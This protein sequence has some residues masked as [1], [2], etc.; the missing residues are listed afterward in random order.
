MLVIFSCS[1]DKFEAKIPSYITIDKFTL[2]TNFATQGSN[3]ESI[4]DAWVFI[5]DDLIGTFELP[6]RFPVLK[7]GVFTIKIFA[8]IKDNGVSQQRRRYLLYAPHEE[9]VNLV[10]GNELTI[11]PSIS[12]NP[13]AKFAWL[14]DFEGASTSFSYHANSDTIINKI[15]TGV[16]EGSYS[17]K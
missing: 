3:S 12:Y 9:Q 13:D 8:G 2:S 14:E 16:F 17:G 5:N 6:A 7:E 4:T 1:K 15:N 10:P 11:T